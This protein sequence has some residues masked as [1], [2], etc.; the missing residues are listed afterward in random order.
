MTGAVA[1]PAVT[2]DTFATEVLAADLP[3]LVEFWA[4][5]CPPCRQLDP[6]LA[7]LA[8]E[9]AGTLAVRK[10]NADENTATVLAHQVLAVPTTILFRDGRPVRTFVGAQPKFR[11]AAGID[12]ALTD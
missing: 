3:V 11:L 7:E 4:R 8:G 1:I 6:V 2:D 5:W 9:R 10:I 12:A